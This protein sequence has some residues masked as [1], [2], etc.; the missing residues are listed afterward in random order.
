MRSVTAGGVTLY[1]NGYTTGFQYNTT[2]KPQTMQFSNGTVRV[3]GIRWF[4]TIEN[5]EIMKLKILMMPLLALSMTCCSCDNHQTQPDTPAEPSDCMVRFEKDGS[6]EYFNVA[7]RDQYKDYIWY[8]FRLRHYN[9]HSAMKYMDLWRIDWAYQGRY[10]E[11]SGEM[12]NILDKI[13]TDGESE[14]VI[15]DYGQKRSDGS[16]YIDTDDFTGGFHGDERIDLQDG[17]GVT[18]YID[19]V[20][21]TADDMS[22]SFGWRECGSFRYVQQSTMHKTAL[23]SGEGGAA[24]ETDHHVVAEHLKTTVFGDAGYVTENTLVMKDAID[25]FWHNGICCVGTSVAQFGYNEDMAVAEFDR[26]GGN[27][28]SGNGKSE[29]VAWSDDNAIE[30]HVKANI[31]EGAED[32]QSYMYIWDT[33]NYAKYYRRWPGNGAHTAVPGEKFTSRMTVTFMTR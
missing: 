6:S 7:V 20:A 28:L 16:G 17:C 22:A 10:D 27:K 24:E 19:D 25:F 18:F 30:V 32:S 5:F 13:L 15:K 29:Y 2:G 4:G 33:S 21:L 3:A 14:C 1:N 8:V 31:T 26:R 9:D 23:K 12:E 11:A